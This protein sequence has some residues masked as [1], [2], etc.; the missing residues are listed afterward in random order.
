M[1][2]ASDQHILKN[3]IVDHGLASSPEKLEIEYLGGGVS[4]IVARIRSDQGVFVLKQALAKLKVK[5][6]WL[7]DVERAL[8]EKKVLQFLPQVIPGKTPRLIFDDPD[9]FLFIMES[10]PEGSLNWK[11]LLMQGDCDSEVAIQ[12][13][14]FISEVHD[15]TKFNAEIALMFEERKYFHQLRI[16]P[17]FA[18]LVSSYP[19]LEK[20][21]NEHI[22]ETWAR[23]EC[24][25]LGDYSPKNILV[26]Q[27]KIIPIDFEVA[28]YGDPS[29]DLGFLW[30]HL[31]LKGVHFSDIRFIDLIQDTWKGYRTKA[32]D[33]AIIEERGIRQLGFLLLARM[34][35]KS[36]VEYYNSEEKKEI[37]RRLGQNIIINRPSQI[38]EVSDLVLQEIQK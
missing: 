11:Q 1:I 38:A 34:D 25:V 31:V 23:R 16:A 17:F 13:G 18:Y 27:D 5:V 26:Y 12:V 9:N 8:V 19:N 24:L 15:K 10:A 2:D 29:F 35:G 22:E 3:Y 14:G 7:S 21:I 30:T 28:H 20:Q 33:L 36:P 32:M 4:N 6:E 37:I